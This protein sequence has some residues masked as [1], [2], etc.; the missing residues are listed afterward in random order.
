MKI[1]VKVLWEKYK[2]KCQIFRRQ[3]KGSLR[4]SGFWMQ[5][6]IIPVITQ[7]VVESKTCCFYFWPSGESQE[8]S[9]HMSVFA[10][11]GKIYESFN[12][13]PDKS[14][15]QEISEK[16]KLEQTGQGKDQTG[17]QDQA[18]RIRKRL[19]SSGECELDNL[20]K[21][22]WKWPYTLS[23]VL[24]RGHWKGGGWVSGRGGGLA[25]VRSVNGIK[26][27]LAVRLEQWNCC[28]CKL[29]INGIIWPIL[30]IFWTVMEK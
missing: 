2:G 30:V 7:V 4:L 14:Q 6:I 25:V 24:I 26:V 27:T 22:S 20:L 28:C 23:V 3:L 1:F 17:T 19:E 9:E 21:C 16:N 8:K 5:F 12:Q 15:N 18:A 29:Y 13:K 10:R 11:R